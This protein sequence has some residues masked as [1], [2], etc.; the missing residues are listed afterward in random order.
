LKA[1]SRTSVIL[2]IVATV[3]AGAAFFLGVQIGSTPQPFRMQIPPTKQVE[4]YGLAISQPDLPP[5]FGIVDRSERRRID[6][7]A[8]ALELGWNKGYQIR[9]ARIGGLL[10]STSI[11]QQISFYPEERMNQVLQLSMRGFSV[12]EQLTIPN[13][14]DRSVAFKKDN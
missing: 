14:G 3:L 1:I 12:D 10:N 5:G 4:P 8:D 11:E 9:F 13:I 2:V 7:S 6:V